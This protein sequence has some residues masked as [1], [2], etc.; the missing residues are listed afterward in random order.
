[1]KF[2]PT[3]CQECIRLQVGCCVNNE[4]NVVLAALPS[5]IA[6]AK[7]VSRGLYNR[8]RDNYFA[9]L[10]AAGGG[11]RWWWLRGRGSSAGGAGGGGGG[12]GGEG[13]GR[14]KGVMVVEEKSGGEGGWGRE[15][16]KSDVCAGERREREG[17]GCTGCE[18]G[19]VPSVVRAER[20]CVLYI[21]TYDSR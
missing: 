9:R 16:E 15:A 1:M 6:P 14:N 19:V 20:F 18:S 7:T 3:P 10:A 17:S 13:W 5:Q 21:C 2:P 11:G 4:V 8:A 12:S